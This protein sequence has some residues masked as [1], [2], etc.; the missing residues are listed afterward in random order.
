MDWM[1][2]RCGLREPQS[3]DVAL[4]RLAHSTILFI[5]PHP[6]ILSNSYFRE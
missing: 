3:Y 6:V 5:L 4:G 2:R 1:N